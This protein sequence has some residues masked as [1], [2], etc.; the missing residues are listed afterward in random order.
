MFKH[1]TTDLTCMASFRHIVEKS[2][3]FI[4][5]L[6]NASFSHVNRCCNAVANKLAKLAKYSLDPQIW[7]EDIHRNATN[8]VIID[9]NFQS[10]EY[11]AL[12]GFSKKKKKMKIFLKFSTTHFCLFHFNLWSNFLFPVFNTM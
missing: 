4:S 5:R 6:R 7:L 2:W 8:L 1:I 11:K 12:V 3:S 9:R 10:I